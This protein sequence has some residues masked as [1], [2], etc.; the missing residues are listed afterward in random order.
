MSSQAGLEVR[1][2]RTITA[3]LEGFAILW[4]TCP[5][6]RGQVINPS[7]WGQWSGPYNL[8]IP[9]APDPEQEREIAHAIVLPP[10]GGFT[11][12]VLFIARKP[13]CG[14]GHV[15]GWVWKPRTPGNAELIELPAPGSPEDASQD[16]FCSGHAVLPD[17]SVLI[18]GGLDHVGK[19]DQ[20]VCN[21]GE[22]PYGHEFLRRLDTS[23]DPP[24]WVNTS[25]SL[26]MNRER[27]YP[28]V[29][30]LNDGDAFIAGHGTTAE[31]DGPGACPPTYGAEAIHETWDRLQWNPSALSNPALQISRLFDGVCDP[32]DA[33]ASVGDYPRL[34]L[35]T[36]GSIV[37][38]EPPITRF[39]DILTP[40]CAVGRW[41]SEPTAT[42]L[43]ARN[44]GNSVHLVYDDPA[45]GFAL[46][47]VVYAI[48]GTDGGDES[49]CLPDPPSAGDLCKR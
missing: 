44:G 26:V 23:S 7:E 29:I 19:C 8:P 14:S 34:H 33:F 49:T 20:P 9:V 4:L 16:A 42:P 22:D 46:L 13:T 40:K 39:L 11:E 37:Q 27:W 10:G 35:L 18:A 41:E 47:D 45:P 2:V 24:L 31:P 3:V 21:P 17:G 6:P 48:G 1:A 28:T 30:T 15:T 12:R 43:V 32:T 25:P 5:T 38:T 36:T